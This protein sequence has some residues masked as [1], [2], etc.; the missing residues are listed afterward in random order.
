M[1]DA[2]QARAAQRGTAVRW[3][4]GRAQDTAR[5]LHELGFLW[6]EEPLPL[7]RLDDLARLRDSTGMP[8]A[9]GERDHTVGAFAAM[10]ASGAYDIVQPD[11]LV[12]GRV[13]SLLE[14]VDRAAAAG[15]PCVFHHGGGGLAAYAHAHMAA[16]AARSPWFEII[17]D[18]PGEIPWP[19]QLA[20]LVPLGIDAAGAV[21]VGD[22]PGLGVDLDEAFLDRFTVSRTVIDRNG[23]HRESR[24]S[25]SA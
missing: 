13:G 17:R 9:G 23:Q 19:A 18:R 6:L 12:V 21:R 22:G 24:R 2:N 10:F 20:P 16:G 15:V 25:A 8:I 3:S 14:I 4:F 7:D 11:G 1:A 5:A